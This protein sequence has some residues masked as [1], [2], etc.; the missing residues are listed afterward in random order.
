MAIKGKTVIRKDGKVI[1]EVLDRTQ[2]SLCSEV[3][4]VTNRLGRQVSDEHIG[5]E[6]DEVHNIETSG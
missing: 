3:Y 5:P 1:T 6:C 4:K 2:G